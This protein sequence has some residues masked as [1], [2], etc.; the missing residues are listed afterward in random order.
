MKNKNIR[1]EIRRL[2]I[3]MSGFII[4]KWSD[5]VFD[6]PGYLAYKTMITKKV[7]KTGMEAVFKGLIS[8]IVKP[9]LK[10]CGTISRLIFNDYLSVFNAVDVIQGLM[11]L[12]SILIKILSDRYKNNIDKMSTA[13]NIIIDV[14]GNSIICVSDM[15]KKRDF[16]RVETIMM[17]G[18]RM[19]NIHNIDKLCGL[20]LEAA[21]IESGSDRA[22]IMLLEKDGFMHIKS[23]IGIPKRIVQSTKVRIGSGI[24]GIAAKT[25]EP[26][27][28]NK[29]YKIPGNIKK[30]MRGLGLK[31][32]L[33][34]PIMSDNIVQGVLNLGKHKSRYLFDRDDAELLMILAHE[35]GTAIN[36][37]RLFE[38][39]HDLYEGSIVSLAAAIEARDQYT[40]GHSKR[41]SEISAS[42][43]RFLKLPADAVKRIKLA[44]M[45]H[46]IGK[47]GLPDRILLKPGPLTKKEYDVVKKHPLYAVNILK[48]LLRLKGIIPIIY[49][50]HERYD[51][52]GYPEGLKSDSIPSESRVIAVA[53]AYEAMTSDRPYRKSMT[54]KKALAEIKRNSGTQFDPAVVRVFLKLSK[55]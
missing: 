7:H 55:Y 13:S 36:N 26:I 50:E 46:D 10:L 54:R 44:S 47:I 42:I 20:I 18:K 45:L 1:K 19:I 39:M 16:A 25:K 3:P 35:A 41:V 21:V 43:A 49:H 17:Y 33:S 40:H 23:S 32:A 12:R 31:S 30:A 22:S 48:H 29:G 2:F 15:Y 51:G 28:I 37:S 27:I 38:D 5:S 11:I 4:N 53:D 14:I 8:D 24:A 9:E 52:C 34:I 6:I